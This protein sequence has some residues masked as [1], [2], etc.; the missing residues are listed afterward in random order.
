M[1]F[2]LDARAI[3]A[4]FR[5]EDGAPEVRKLFEDPANEC[6]VHAI[7]LHAINLC[8][9]Y[10][11]FHRVGRP[12]CGNRGTGGSAASRRCRKHENER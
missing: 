11:D 9:V 6:I 5:N 2:V 1:R 10:H 7:N 8:E 12:R 4:Y 3:I